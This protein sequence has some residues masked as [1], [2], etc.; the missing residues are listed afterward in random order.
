[1]ASKVLNFTV[2]FFFCQ[3]KCCNFSMVLRVHRIMFAK[4]APFGSTAACRAMTALNGS[5]MTESLTI[6]GGTSTTTMRS[7]ITGIIT[8]KEVPI[9]KLWSLRKPL[10]AAEMTQTIDASDMASMTRAGGRH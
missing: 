1:M 8:Q 4:E 7:M 2:S 10:K 5:A 3:S 9:I 6:S